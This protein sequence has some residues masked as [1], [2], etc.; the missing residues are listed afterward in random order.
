[1]LGNRRGQRELFDVG[2]VYDLAL[3]ATS[4]HAQLAGA[5]PQ[6]FSDAEFAAFYAEKMGRPS[7]PPSLLALMT[8]L[9]HEAGCSDEEAVARTAFDLRWAAVLRRHAGTPLCAKSTF[10]LFRAHLV[11]HDAVRTIFQ[12]SIQ[13][14]KRASLL[15]GGT[16]RIAVDTKPILGRGAVED[17]YN[18]LGTGIQQLG[19]ALATLAGQAPERWAT[20]HDLGR[21][22]GA[23]LKGS[24]DLDWSDPEAKQ[25]FLTEIVADARRLLR[26]AGERL[27]AESEARGEPVRA[28]AALLEQLLLQ[29]VVET[30]T[31]GGGSRAQLKEGTTPG[32]IP[33]A[34]DPEIRH[35]RKSKSKRFNGHKAAVA[36]DVATQLIVDAEVL[37]GDAPDA[38]G[39]LAAVGRVEE[40]TGQLVA[41]TLGDC[42]YGSGAT[43]QA[44]AEAGRELVAK[45]PQERANQGRFPKSVFH[46]DLLND[47]VTCPDGA[48]TGEFTL[49]KDGTKVFRFRDCMNCWRR[50]ACT[51]AE[52]R[53]VRVHPQEALL[54]A[55]RALQQSEE[56]RA[57]LRERVAAEHAL[58]RLGQLGIGQACYVGRKKTRLQLLLSAT[59][60]NLR[61]TWRWE[62]EQRAAAE[63][64][65]A[66]PSLAVQSGPAGRATRRGALLTDLAAAIGHGV[67]WIGAGRS[68]RGWADRALTVAWLTPCRSSNGAFRLCF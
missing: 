51:P 68:V 60:A 54:Q 28:A 56:G 63:A 45:V 13:E 61:R 53:T 12:R 37:A 15:K 34:T 20:E 24:A 49:G 9:Q 10:Q 3:P 48:T 30:P 46:L 62:S 19:R 35:G 57:T 7:V 16:L 38:E 11:L 25:A 21:Y 22:F 40:N 23:S 66:N 67:R 64:A 31:S 26:H 8:L 65:E 43:R 33:S 2:N 27:A 52:G 32:R 18:L 50:D 42:A 29:D 4:F 6:L 36:T 41:Q 55:A 44:F 59:V 5:A 39:V 47:T 14:A 58:A 1:M 17:T